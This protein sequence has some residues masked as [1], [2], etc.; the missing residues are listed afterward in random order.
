MSNYNKIVIVGRVGRDPEVRTTTTGKQVADFS[1]AVNR[2]K[3]KGTEDVTDWFRVSA[4]DRLA[5]VTSNYLT[6][7]RLVLVE[8][9]MQCRKYTDASGNN[10]ESW[11]VTADNMQIL[12]RPREDGGGAA[13][14]EPIGA[15]VASGTPA[16]SGDEYDP[17]ADQ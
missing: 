8:G 6:K 14:T 16:P 17:F 9:R 1:V 3:G 2:N 10:R 7:G 15:G 4:W 12:D 11:E 13:R 5:E